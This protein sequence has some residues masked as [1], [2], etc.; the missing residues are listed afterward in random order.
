MVNIFIFGKNTCW[1]FS[2]LIEYMN[3]QM[4]IKGLWIIE[5]M[6]PQSEIE[7]FYRFKWCLDVS[8]SGKSFIDK[9]F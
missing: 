1:V 4:K 8:I 6:K 3:K 2:S 5:M 9:I 7:N